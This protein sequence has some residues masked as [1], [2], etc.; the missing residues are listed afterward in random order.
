MVQ[1]SYRGE[2]RALTGKPEEA[3][4]A[5]RVKDILRYI[6]AS[7][8]RDAWREA[9]TMLITVNSESILQLQVF[10]TSLKDSVIVCF[11]RYAAAVKIPAG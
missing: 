9:K 8:G 6:K 2:L 11:R 10:N 7:Y 5:A 4:A 3:I 1:V